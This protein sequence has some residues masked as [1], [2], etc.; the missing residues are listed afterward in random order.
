MYDAVGF[1]FSPAERDDGSLSHCVDYKD[2]QI[3]CLDHSG[4]VSNEIYGSS[5]NYTC[6]CEL[7]KSDL[8][9]K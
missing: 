4:N 8:K 3:V 2:A 7:A 1:H 5:E 9:R 6:F